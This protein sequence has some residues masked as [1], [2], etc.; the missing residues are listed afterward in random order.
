MKYQLDFRTQYGQFYL[1][2]KTS[3][4]NTE[5]ADFWTDEAFDDRLAMGAGIL[6]VGTECY[7]HVKGEVHILN[8]ASAQND[9]NVFDHVVEG[10]IVIQSGLLEVLDCPNS[11]LELE[12]PLT[13]GKYRARV[14]SSRLA[15]VMDDDGDDYYIIEIWP[16]ENTERV[17]L[18]RYRKLQG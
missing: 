9:F 18:K 8:S 2:D 10:G 11:H 1:S 5:A 13:P 3:E 6:G 12:I 7:G 15:S 4:K 17:V 16:D 14:Y